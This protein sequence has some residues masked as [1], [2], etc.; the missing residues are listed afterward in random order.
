LST[1]RWCGLEWRLAVELVTED[2]IIRLELPRGTPRSHP[3]SPTS[4][5]HGQRFGCTAG[6]VHLVLMPCV[7][8]I[9]VTFSR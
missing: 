1:V 2:N 6:C 5:L 8:G 9:L 7:R 4:L 3:G